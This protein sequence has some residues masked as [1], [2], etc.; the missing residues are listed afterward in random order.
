[1][2]KYYKVYCNGKEKE[3][4]EGT[5]FKEISTFFEKDYQYPVLGVKVNEDFL[6]LGSTITKDSEISFFTRADEYG[7]KIYSKSARFILILAVK[8]VYGAKAKVVV[9]HSQDRGM[10]FT[11]NGVKDISNS[12]KLINSEFQ[13]IVNDDYL[14][15]RLTVS[16]LEAINYFSKKRSEDKADMLKYISNTY[17]NL[18]RLDNVYDY[19]YGRMAYSTSQIDLFEVKKLD[20]GYVLK[21]PTIYAP[22][23]LSIDIK[24]NKLQDI[25]F[26]AVDFSTNINI[27]TVSDL[28][29]RVSLGNV[30]DIILMSEAFYD[31]QLM[32]VVDEIIKKKS[33]VI[34]LAGPSSSGKTTSAKKL[35][36]FL[37]T[38]G[39]NTIS[40][41]LDDYF[42][43]LDKRKRL[44]DGGYD[45]ESINAV[46]TKLFEEQMRNLINGEEVYLP[47][48]DF[49]R[50]QS[51][52][53]KSPTKIGRNDI[54]V[55]EGI[56]AL[57]DKLAAKLDNKYKF[58][59]YISPLSSI[60]IDFHNPIHVTDIRK[61]RRIVRD[62]RSRGLGALETLSMWD[63]IQKG[64]LENIYPY[65]NTVDAAI[66]SS[67]S[68]ELGVLKTYAEPLLYSV[69][70]D[71]EE[72]PEALRLINF[73]HNFLP[74]P[75]DDIPNDS[76]IREFIGGSCFK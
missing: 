30:Q 1:M 14:F 28:N 40:V 46:N 75:S 29:Y 12:E 58:K 24:H 19:F 4:K 62:S 42:T 50:G 74:I 10:Y 66:N 26:Q 57:N 33:R 15:T 7:N 53:R 13:K 32:N 44:P 37:R 67:L 5:T 6:D 47:Y 18:Y 61:L 21:L 3:F 72:Y 45:F 54:I 73:L 8:R 65:Q 76:V 22:D 69:K 41:S 35:S 55:V 38:K 60:C 48:Y 49:E 23:K 43:D 16:R 27:K 11:I 2:D 31:R 25:F 59:I 56:H 39:Y 51:S 20:G 17:I 9:V 70:E 64:E 36:I 34:L 63:E 52:F 71:D 68:Y